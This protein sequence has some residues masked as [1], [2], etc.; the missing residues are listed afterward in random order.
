VGLNPVIV[1]IRYS[2]RDVNRAAPGN[3]RIST[4]RVTGPGDGVVIHE[5]AGTGD[6]G[7]SASMQ[8]GMGRRALSFLA[9]WSLPIILGLLPL[10][11]LLSRESGL[12]SEFKTKMRL[13][14]VSAE[15]LL[16]KG[17]LESYP[18]LWL[19]PIPLWRSA[20]TSDR[21]AHAKM[22]AGIETLVELLHPMNIA[23][24]MSWIDDEFCNTDDDYLTNTPE[25]GERKGRR[26][27]RDEWG[28]PLV[29]IPASA[30][31]RVER[32]PETYVTAD[33]THVSVRPW[34]GEDGAFEQPDSFQLF[35]MGPDDQPNTDDDILCW[36]D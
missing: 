36:R 27:I 35:S 31:R 16:L 28:N 19:D 33:G 10:S 21:P 12:S 14:L 23:H 7:T 13:L 26:E 18:P 34:R 1:A 15:T 29:Y 2:G 20:S 17:K 22:N 11:G 9:A 3:R 8:D 25:G 32:D 5:K 24:P 6:R 4:G 30:Y